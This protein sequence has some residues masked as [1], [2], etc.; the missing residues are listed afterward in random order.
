[1]RRRSDP[2][3]SHSQDT[4]TSEPG[5]PRLGQILRDNGLLSER[6]LSDGLQI[7]Q[8][9]GRPLGEVLE[10]RGHVPGTAL[11]AALAEQRGHPVLDLARSPADPLVSEG[12]LPEQLLALGLLPWRRID[13]RLWCAV[14]EPDDIYRLKTSLPAA[15]DY[16]EFAL[17]DR[18]SIE[19]E[20]ARLHAPRLAKAARERCPAHLSCRSWADGATSPMAR[21]ALFA[22]LLGMAFFP[23]IALISLLV[24]IT[25]INI[26][27]TGLRGFSLLTSFQRPPPEVIGREDII[28]LPPPGGL[29]VV[30]IFVP[31]YQETATLRRLIS[32]LEESTYPKELLDVMF[33]LEADDVA[34]PLALAQMGLPPWIRV[35][36][37][38]DDTLKTKP[39]AMNFALGFARGSVIGIYDAEDQPEPE[40]LQKIVRALGHAKPDVACV[41][42]YLDF[43]NTR[44]NFLSRCFTV[45]YA[46]WFRVILRGVQKLGMPIPLGG[47]TVFFKRSALEEVGAWDAH[48]VTED[49][50]LGMRLARFS[51]RTEMVATTTFEE[52]NCRPKAWIKQRSRWLKGYAMTWLTHMRRPRSLWRD[53]GPRGFLGFQLLLLGGLT[54]YLAT[55]LFWLLWAGYWVGDMAIFNVGPSWLWTLFFSAMFVGQTVMLMVAA[56]AVWARPRR[57]LLLTVP[58]L[59]LYWPLGAIAAYRAVIEIFTKPFHWAKTEHGL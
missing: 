54:A 40:Q 6:E 24:W 28:A 46:I 43:Y 53:L 58:F 34:T 4:N 49:A 13:G 10:R 8:R 52:A 31:L 2:T 55:P 9:V 7:H 47:T 33:L 1:M 56:R 25:V 36:T 37:A 29:P 16:L 23:A 59:A 11:A 14:A 15:Q 51:Y 12:Q 17:A 39:R 27:T 38:P 18:N 41:Q 19:A 22:V 5:R 32:A 35:L 44:Q 57:R 3:F 48:N 50:D 45:E 26:A 20:I 21:A 42:G 30:S